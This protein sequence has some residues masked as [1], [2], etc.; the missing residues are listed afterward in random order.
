MQNTTRDRQSGFTLVELMITV[1]IIA[2]LSAV[3]SVA[4]KKYTGRAR[5]GEAVS[6]LSEMASKEMIYYSEFA[7]YLPLR[8]DNNITMPS[9]NEGVGAFYPVSPSNATFESARTAW[10]ISNPI[11]WPA[12]W[13]SIGLR[14][15][16]AS[17]YCTYLTNAGQAA[18]APAAGTLGVTMFR[19]V[20]AT[21][22]PWFYSLADC[23]LNGAA[24]FPTLD[25][26]L[27]LT[28][29]SPTLRTWND[30]M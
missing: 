3:A 8:N 19:A 29:D 24:G 25:T 30:S 21:T 6:V 4:Y 17:L 2:I 10:D 26:V 13:R 12:A 28:S 27:G 23:N 20:T 14:V 1:A 11:A 5:L 18:T 22:P 7:S 15:R 16:Q 9:P